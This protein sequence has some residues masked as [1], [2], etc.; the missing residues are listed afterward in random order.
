MSLK[1][2]F[3]CPL[4]NGIHAR[5][6]SVFEEAMR[7]FSSEIILVNERNG[8]SAN[9]RS[10][11][12]IIGADIRHNDRCALKV[13]GPDEKEAFRAL[14]VFVEKALPHCDDPL[15]SDVASNGKFHLP[16][17]ALD[18]NVTVHTGT[19]VV[20]GVAL[21]RIVQ[22]GGFKIPPGLLLNG[23]HDESGERGKLEEGLQKLIEFYDKRAAS[24][25]RKI[26]IELYKAHRAIARDMEFQRQLREGVGE[27][28]QTAAGAIAGAE[29]HF[30]KMLAAAGSALLRERA[31]DI[32]DVCS[33]LLRQIYGGASG[34]EAVRLESDAI[35]V[36]ETLAPGQFLALDRKYLKGL[37]LGHTGTTSHT[38]ILARSFGI[39]TLAGV[40][41]IAD[42]RLE[43][44][45]AVLDADGG[46]LLTN[47]TEK[48]R[49]YYAME[50]QRLEARRGRMQKFE[51]RAATTQDGHRIEIGANIAS[52]EEA[53]AAFAGG[54][55]GVGLFR[56]EML[57][58]DRES[59]PNETEQFEIYR[60]ALEAA[61]NH[62]VIIRTLD[63]GGD[64]PLD[65]LNLPTE[66][67]PFLG[68][69]G[70]RLYEKFEPLFRTQIRALVRASA[71]GKLKLLLPM[72][73]TMDEARRAKKIILEEQ[74][75]CA[76]EKIPYDA[77]MPIGAMIEVP[78]AAFLMDAL[79]AEFDFF[80]IGSND[81]LQYFM[82]AD[83]GNAAVKA[84]YNPLQPAFLQL[85]N[86]IVT[87]ARKHQK[88]I[89]LCGEAGAEILPLLAGLGLDEISVS[90]PAIP[91]LKAEIAELRFTD[92]QRL[93]AA[94]M[95]CATADEAAALLKQ[96]LMQR[97]APLTEPDLVILDSGA[98]TKEEAI[99]QA[100]DRLYVTGRT[101]NSRALEE[102]IWQRE[103]T[104]STG[105][106]H[107]FAIPHCKT[108]AVRF[109]SLALVKL[110]T[111]VHWNSLDGRLVQVAVLF[112]ARDNNG[113]NGHMKV[114][115]R[116][117]R[118]M[119]DENF[120]AR[121]ENENDA[122][123]LCRI[124]RDALPTEAAT[125]GQ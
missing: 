113:A 110:R 23:D 38:V 80:S 102:A 114:F 93:L 57:F 29:N 86:Q 46:A 64:K 7:D 42:G 4:P 96:F 109:N 116:L 87:A 125:T 51:A 79:C 124:M 21:G 39:P 61:G 105:F 49:R 112:A 76:A 45:E 22:I 1:R 123:A 115:A 71:Q 78:S 25:K 52:A 66:E 70:I 30:S 40:H 33:E 85:L 32:Q 48:A 19:R 77:Q 108:D 62:A 6:A 97:G 94:A 58:L 92:C 9:A 63:A 74:Q 90:A 118:L 60:R 55:E 122:Q 35:V 16:S 100:A 121:I 15:A 5:P 107:G 72:V 56:T 84:L 3:I 101:E 59:A 75:K 103:Q 47:L 17:M 36:A 73:A 89:G 88:W 44:Q 2:Q 20:G 81:L 120:R 31:L 14:E 8:R 68:C 91:G 119:M 12:A 24:A 111:P 95:R 34:P 50:Q 117:A 53:P 18:S 106:G 27:R 65:Y 26:E 67:N 82:A 98:Q 69:R 99:K 83:R 13:S 41:E 28:K 43:N 104:Y 37:A 11:L 54:A 10:V